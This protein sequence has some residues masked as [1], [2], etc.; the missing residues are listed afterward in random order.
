MSWRNSGGGRGS[1]Y[2]SRNDE[3]SVFEGGSAGG[4]PLTLL[5]GACVLLGVL[6]L[7]LAFA[8]GNRAGTA[9]TAGGAGA[10][11]V[12]PPVAAT[13]AAPTAAPAA[14]TAA[15]AA[16]AGVPTEPLGPAVAEG[17]GE[18][19]LEVGTD[20]AQLVFAP[21]ALSAPANTLV[22]LT[23]NNLAAAVQHNW[24]LVDGGDDVAEAVNAAAQ[25][26]VTRETGTAGAVPP[27]DTPGLLVAVPMINAGEGSTVTFET[28]GPGTYQFICTFPGHY[29]A[30]MRGELTVE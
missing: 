28:P 3:G 21:N 2:R 12:Q 10:P 7:G 19:Q 27:A 24:V 6:G 18:E 17:E 26:G 8:F 20:V 14:P 25:A 30:G 13:V 22:T 15:P 5:I 9:Q 11:Q 16:A 23:F 29:I 4:P 1:G